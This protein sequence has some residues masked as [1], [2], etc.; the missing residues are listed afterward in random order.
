MSRKINF[1]AALLA[2]LLAAPMTVF[3][4]GQTFNPDISVILDGRYSHYLSE[5]EYELPGFMLSGEAGN[6]EQGFSLGH[7][8]LVMSANIDDM[9]YGKLTAAIHAGDE[10]SE[11]EL[12]EA[13][14][15][16]LTLGHGA[17]VK[18]GR[19]F[20]GI[21]YL[22]QHHPHSWDFADAPLVYRGLFGEQL[23][24]DGIQ[25]R[26]VAP[27][28]LF[29][30]LGAELGRGAQFPAGG[31]ANEGSGTQALFVEF[32]G[33]VGASHS[34]QLGLSHWQAEV[35]AREGGG[36]AHGAVAVETP[37]FRG[38]SE[39]SALDFVWKWAPNGNNRER[40]LKF[41]FEY[42]MRDEEGNIELEGSDPLEE[43]SYAGTQKG[44]YSQLV[45]QFM[46]QWRIGARYDRL[47][48]DNQGEDM[49]ILGEAGLDDEGHTPNR[50]SLMVDYSRSEFSRLRLQ[51]NRDNSSEVEDNYLMLQYVMSL[52][53]HG[54]HSF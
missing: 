25:L 18:A 24:D 36:H 46:P 26:W 15:E 41:Q 44:W 35:A 12:E 22:N 19:F 31:A 7:S 42:F 50:I 4:Q 30:Q 54:A 27:T 16:T 6:G 38:D 32:G 40:N 29:I 49:A 3:A 21:G 13:Y 48:A 9:Y 1:A 2:A 39:I 52:G 5:A 20:S 45:Y 17:T 34:W 51:Y 53:S 23:F 10:G 33:D 11:L 28:D 47:E 14:I 8:E 37:V 43:S